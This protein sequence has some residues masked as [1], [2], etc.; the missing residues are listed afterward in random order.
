MFRSLGLRACLRLEHP[1]TLVPQWGITRSGERT[2]RNLATT[3]Q[4]IRSTQR[5]VP[6]D[7][8]SDWGTA[9]RGIRGVR[10]RIPP[11]LR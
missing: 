5:V 4:A 11:K 7:R 3:R 6:S 9:T 8:P 10:K 1:V 2:T